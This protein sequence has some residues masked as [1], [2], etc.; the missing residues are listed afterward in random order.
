MD[1]PRARF[2]RHALTRKLSRFRSGNERKQSIKILLCHNYYR[3][4]GGE[5]QCFEDESRLLESRGH[6]VVRYTVHND[7]VADMRPWTAARRTFWN[8]QSFDALNEIVRRER[9][10]IMHCTNTFPLI[11]PACYA[12]ARAGNVPVV[13]ALHNY[14]LVCSNAFLMREGR[15]CEDCLGKTFAWPGILHRCYRN[16]AAASSVVATAIAAHRLKGTWKRSVD[17]YYAV[18]D[19]ARRKLIEGNLP[20]DKIAVKPNFV[21][22]DPGVGRGRGGYAIFVGRLSPEK[23][24]ETLLSA[25]NLLSSDANGLPLK[26]VGDGPSAP[27]V[28]QAAAANPRIEWLGSRP[29]AEVLSLVGDATLLVMPSIWYETFG[30]TIIE[31][32]ATGTPVVVSNLGAMAELVVD[33][34]TGLLFDPGNATDLAR[35][36]RSLACDADR[37]AAMRR[38][39]RLEFEA[40]FTAESNYHRLMELYS[41][42]ME[43]RRRAGARRAPQDL[44]TSE[45]VAS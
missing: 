23:G 28:Q 18:S 35:K 7:S 38:A 41:R 9:P 27:L 16:S 8:R 29:F 11:S 6:E 31:A 36:V 2:V 26:I 32:Y 33:G 39:A 19:F 25:W 10:E 34:E 43:N 44:E 20:A 30:R 3:L 14:R 13:Q 42:A 12:A 4:R 40:K 1:T 24:L 37:L 17:L 21:D 5:D 15:V 45:A 22:P